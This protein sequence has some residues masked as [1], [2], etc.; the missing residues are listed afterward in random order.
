V[1]RFKPVRDG[2]GALVSAFSTRGAA[3]SNA[4][5]SDLPD[6]RWLAN[7]SHELRTPLNI[8]I[9]LSDM[10][11]NERTLKLDDARRSDY[12]QL[13]HASGNHLL[14]LIDGI[15]DLARLE[16][17]ADGPRP[18]GFSPA[19]AIACCTD[20]LAF[21]A[22]RAG[23]ELIVA[24]PQ[25]L[26]DLVADQRAFK[27]ILINLLS[28]AIKFTERGHVKLSA[29]IECQEL[30]VRIEDTGVGISAEDLPLVGSAFFR[31][32]A[33]D[34]R[35]P[36]GSGLGL[37][38]VKELISRNGGTFELCSRAGEGTCATV[39]LPLKPCEADLSEP[40]RHCAQPATVSLA[41]RCAHAVTT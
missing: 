39:R 30:V 4:P 22:K 6:T 28:N 38:I 14:S 12:A 11:I 26:P 1:S 41:A 23:L 5:A 37:S 34:R 17:G 13:I 3:P 40:P 35:A 20:M 21:D 18:Q 2:I 16:A 7:I 24:V 19:Q 33:N 8:V 36:E 9:G 31:A 10:L 25:M 27:Q 15:L 29:G 32:Q